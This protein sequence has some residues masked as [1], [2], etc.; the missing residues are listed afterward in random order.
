[1]K[2]RTTYMLL[3]AT[4]L[5]IGGSQLHKQSLTAA[6][7][8]TTAKTTTL[9]S[10]NGHKVTG[11]LLAAG[12]QWQIITTK[13]IHGQ[14]LAKI[15]AN[16][17]T[18]NPNPE[19]PQVATAQNEQTS[20]IKTQTQPATGDSEFKKV[21]FPASMQGTWYG[22]DKDSD[23]V[24]SITFA[25]NKISVDGQDSY[26]YDGSV[27]PADDQAILNTGT[28]SL[29]AEQ[30]N[31]MEHW[32]ALSN[33]DPQTANFDTT[34]ISPIVNL[35]GWY[36]SA[37]DG[38]YYYIM[39]ENIDGQQTPVLFAASGAGMWTDMHYYRSNQLAQQQQ[40]EVFA[41]DRERE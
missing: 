30:Q 41:D 38:T 5:S 39:N 6:K 26:A 21:D 14:Q 11:K 10:T 27:R 15:A 3:G 34:P 23:A 25:G 37:G 4:L 1:M 36:Q 40:D 35:R 16:L 8:T 24:K 33:V 28:D 31:R 32:A 12:S 19:Q 22:Y 18:T 20:T 29:N 7:L 13:N 17:W 2:K 9:Y